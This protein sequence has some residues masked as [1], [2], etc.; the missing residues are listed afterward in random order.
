[1]KFSIKV[2]GRV[3][4]IL[5]FLSLVYIIKNAQIK[6]RKNYNV[7]FITIDALRAD[8]LVC[9]GYERNTTPKICS[10][11]EDG[12]LFKSAFSQATYTHASFAS[13]LT[14]K[15]PTSHGIYNF[16]QT[17]PEDQVTILDILKKEGYTIKI[18]EDYVCSLSI[19]LSKRNIS[20]I[21]AY[22]K[23]NFLKLEE[24][25][26]SFYCWLHLADPHS[27][28]MPEEKY[29]GTFLE[30]LSINKTKIEMFAVNSSNEH[31]LCNQNVSE[32][33][34]KY[35]I[36]RYD[37]EI[38]QAD[39]KVGDILEK[40]KKFGLYED[41]LII[42]SADHGEEF[43]EHG[44]FGHG[45]PPF[46]VQI[47]VP[48]IIKFPKNLYSG[49]TV[50]KQVRLID[51]APTILDVLK[52]GKDEEME[53][54]SLID[55]IEGKDITLVVVSQTE[56]FWGVR[57][58]YYKYIFVLGENRSEVDDLKVYDLKKDPQEKFD[59]SEEKLE[60]AEYYKEEIL[61]SKKVLKK[62]EL[63]L[64]E[65]IKTRLIELGYIV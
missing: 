47:H 21:E 48:L 25:N 7:I 4:L 12:V 49:R 61:N 6:E 13:I 65:A 39:D 28:Y 5:M 35:L 34:I 40:L 11:A 26:N 9:Y 33:E 46:D 27:P 54:V 20:V 3:A 17:I 59:I 31:L 29:Y 41:S 2:R 37:E 18:V 44:D 15:I 19:L 10:L 8:H 52:I 36:D 30:N 24:F 62:D 50:E 45:N 22:E 43:M 53:G 42:I 32:E 58:E 16:N 63:E 56:W 14:S 60:L 23:D 55:I 51:L 1:M 64:E 38:R 57:D